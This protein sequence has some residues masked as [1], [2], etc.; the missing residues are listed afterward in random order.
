[1]PGLLTPTSIY[2]DKK[3]EEERC[4]NWLVRNSFSFFE[5]K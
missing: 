2:K 3:K 5:L 4:T 1:M